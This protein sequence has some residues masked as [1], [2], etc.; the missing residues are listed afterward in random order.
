MTYLFETM[1]PC[2]SVIAGD[3]D[4]EPDI[5]DVKQN[6]CRSDYN[7]SNEPYFKLNLLPGTTF[8]CVSIFLNLAVFLTFVHMRWVFAKLFFSRV[9]ATL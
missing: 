8:A 2:H 9:L 1:I 4:D 6:M 5:S 3:G 7:V